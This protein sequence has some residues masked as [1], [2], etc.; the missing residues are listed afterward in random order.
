METLRVSK[1]EFKTGEI[2]ARVIEGMLTQAKASEELGISIRQVKRQCKE[3]KKN[4]LE[5]LTHKSR[6]KKGNRKIS[7]PIREKIIGVI[8]ERY[9]DFGPQLV[10]EQLEETHRLKYS[11]EWL[12]QLMIDAEIWE[13]KKKKKV[14][15]HQRR[16]RRD[17]E[18]ELLQI[19]G[20][21]HDWFEGRGLKCCLINRVDDATGKIKGLRFVEHESTEA[22]FTVMKRYVKDYGIPLAVYSDRHKIFKGEKN[23]SQFS[24][25]L[26]ELGTKPIF[27]NSPQAKGR[28]ERS[29][30]TLQDRLI[31]LMRLKGIDSMEA[32][33]KYLG[34]FI[35]DYNKRFGRRPRSEKDAHIGLLKGIDLERI[36]TIKETRKLS[37][38]LT[39]GYE[40][41]TYQLKTQE[42]SYRLIG[43]NALIYTRK[44][45]VV[46]ECE[47]K[48]YNYTIF[49]D[50]PYQ[51]IMDRKK[52]DAFLDRKQAL[53]GIE[54]HRRGMAVNF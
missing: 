36:F 39:V 12:R 26:K 38:Q 44:G 34:A 53:T 48:E 2:I 45:K 27:A 8:K 11:R 4:G 52:I 28:V 32:G 7:D 40:K 5:G 46:I 47:E 20:S 14:K 3:Y 16:G 29:H 22:Y 21:Y 24:R 51:A 13:A 37:K 54:R 41:K 31:K 23:D 30:A 1:K 6:G 50:Q 43:K 35:L 33:N 9:S 49:E 19:D 18:G 15:Y 17:Q 25:A 42:N 10:K